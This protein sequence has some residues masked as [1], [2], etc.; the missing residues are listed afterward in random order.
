MS[1]NATLQHQLKNGRS[2]WSRSRSQVDRL[3]RHFEGI[4]CERTEMDETQQILERTRQR[5]AELGKENSFSSDLPDDLMGLDD[6]DVSDTKAKHD[7]E[8]GS[9]K[10][11]PS[12]YPSEQLDQLRRDA[13][14][15]THNVTN[16]NIDSP[17]TKQTLHYSKS[18]MRSRFAALSAD[19]EKF[20]CNIKSPRSKESYMKS[21][22][23]RLNVGE[24]RPSALFTPTASYYPVATKEEKHSPHSASDPSITN[25]KA[26]ERSLADTGKEMG[27]SGGE[28][29]L[30]KDSSRR[31]FASS[32]T[33]AL[34]AARSEE[35]HTAQSASQVCQGVSL[36][37]SSTLSNSDEKSMPTSVKSS[38]VVS[39]EPSISSGHQIKKRE[40]EEYGI[41]N[42]FKHKTAEKAVPDEHRP[43][44]APLDCNPEGTAV[45]A[46]VPMS[47]STPKDASRA[48][49][50]NQC[51]VES[52][53]VPTRGDVVDELTAVAKKATAG[54]DGACSNYGRAKSIA[55]KLEQIIKDESGDASKPMKTSFPGRLPLSTQKTPS[56]FPADDHSSWRKDVARMTPNSVRID[57]RSADVK[58]L[59]S[60]WEVSSATGTPLHPDQKPDEL[61]EAAIR[62]SRCVNQSKDSNMKITSLAGIHG[63]NDPLSSTPLGGSRPVSLTASC[64]S[65]E[66]KQPEGL[67]TSDKEA[68]A[69]DLK[70]AVTEKFESAIT[71]QGTAPKAVG[72][73]SGTREADQVIDDLFNFIYQTPNRNSSFMSAMLDTPE[74]R[75]ANVMSTPSTP[76]NAGGNEENIPL[77][78]SV[79]FY[80]KKKSQ[81][82]HSGETIVLGQFTT[83]P[84]QNSD[85]SPPR[86]ALSQGEQFQKE[87]ARLEEAIIVQEKQVA[88]ATRALHFCR[89]TEEFRGSREQVDA[90]RALLIATARRRALIFEL[91]RMK[92][93]KAD[94]ITARLSSGPKGTLTISRISVRLMRDFINGHINYHNDHI[95]FYFIV[96]IRY[97]GI[98]LHT[99]MT[100]S[101]QGIKSGRLEFPHYIQLSSLP[102]DFSCALEVYALRTQREMIEHHEKYRI[103]RATMK[104][105]TKSSMFNAAFSPSP[106]G[107]SS[108]VDPSFQ[109]VG[110]LTLTIAS[111]RK[112]KFQLVDPMSPLDG[113]I[114]MDLKC[115]AEETGTIGHKAFLSLYQ[116]VENMASWTRFWCVLGEGQLRFWRYPEDETTKAPVVS[117]DLRTCAC[118]EIKAI[119][120]ENCPYPNSMQVDVWVPS[121]KHC[122]KRDKIRVLMAADRKDEMHAWLR[123]MNGSLTNLTLWNPRQ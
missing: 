14:K 5:E 78:H 101:D 11:R 81:I 83:S 73:N 37:A 68:K 52:E 54:L 16:L 15:D 3:V 1:T 42:F 97:G 116:D 62:M 61:L 104:R 23:P 105:S 21:A 74:M 51:E 118:N 19:V 120:V 6:V 39:E 18:G 59:R 7:S 64:S 63:S 79:S 113:A 30:T 47:S 70:S 112:N 55:K 117:I 77:A 89:N 56:K 85:S 87:K 29:K 100:T 28:N 36:V 45:N 22:S 88:Q 66:V 110:S 92:Q 103:K 106:D 119:P 50:P 115:Y 86:Q 108:E 82:R 49:S 69:I 31:A 35:K 90:Q 34:D 71:P 58:K 38:V 114:E 12:L 46:A 41:H 40:S 75:S 43:A 20:E 98:V 84:A 53:F 107:P 27:T 76:L 121:E 10:E 102:H 122:G 4:A 57:V 25:G 33:K 72:E 60:R 2:L 44:D 95:L 96:L 48:S 26:V 8:E 13:L 94:G 67:S 123:A 32:V 93:A 24:T 9:A 109:L 65:S 99:T 80:R 91:E 17:K 111:L